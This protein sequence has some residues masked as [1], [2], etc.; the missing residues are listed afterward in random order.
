MPRNWYTSAN[1]RGSWYAKNC[2][3]QSVKGTGGTWGGSANIGRTKADI[4]K[5][6]RK[7]PTDYWAYWCDNNNPG[8]FKYETYYLSCNQYNPVL[9]AYNEHRYHTDPYG[10]NLYV[11]QTFNAIHNLPLSTSAPVFNSFF[12]NTI[13]RDCVNGLLKK[14]KDQKMMILVS[15]GEARQT[16]RLASD[17]LGAVTSTVLHLASGIANPGSIIPKFNKMLKAN[18]GLRKKPRYKSRE[19][20]VNSFY[21]GLYR[22]FERGKVDEKTLLAK[23]ADKGSDLWLS[24]RYGIIPL[25]SDIEALHDI[26]Y[27]HALDVISTGLLAT[28]YRKTYTTGMGFTGDYSGQ[29]SVTDCDS[30]V[31][32]EIKSYYKVNIAEATKIKRMGMSLRDVPAAVYELIPYSFVFDWFYD[33]GD[34]LNALSATYGLTH[35]KTYISITERVKGKTEFVGSIPSAIGGKKGG[36]RG[37]VSYGCFKRQVYS[38]FPVPQLPTF[39]MPFAGFFDDRVFDSIALLNNLFRGKTLT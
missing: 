11:F 34:Y 8:Q 16:A 14:I 12:H 28:R 17:L 29:T 33:V 24:Y 7:T 31:L 38:S 21:S 18:R 13:Y 15:L 20:Y 35:I 6:D 30:E 27:V 4:V 23:A 5:S 22:A 19:H 25:M 39:Q 36:E 3:G 37:D 9:P 2:Q 26:L 32:A 1:R 10:V